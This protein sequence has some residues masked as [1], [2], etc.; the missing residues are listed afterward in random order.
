MVSTARP[1]R[2]L[3]LTFAVLFVLAPASAWTGPGRADEA[4]AAR[5]EPLPTRWMSADGSPK[6]LHAVPSYA[7]PLR[8]T[9]VR[10]QPAAAWPETA[11]PDREAGGRLAVVVEDGLYPSIEPKLLRWVGGL[12]A[13]GWTVLLTRFGA[14][15]PHQLR[16]Y[17]RARFRERALGGLAG[18][19]FVGDL[20]YVLYELNQSW[21]GKTSEYED[22]PCDL[23][24]MDLD[25]TWSDVKNDGAVQPGN[26]KYDTRA[27]D[28][29]LEIWVGRLQTGNLPCLGAEAGIF[30]NYFEKNRAFRAGK[31]VTA[32]AALVYDDD[33][34]ATMAADDKANLKKILAGTAAISGPEATTA[35]DYMTRRMPA[36]LEFMFTR[37]HGWPGG[38]G[39]YRAGK[40]AFERVVCG[41]YLTI[42]PKALF[43]S[44]FVCSGCDF[45]APDNLG[46]VAA[47]NA[48]SGLLSY[49]S[50][51]TGGIWLD[52]TLFDALAAGGTFGSSFLEWFNA[53]QAGYPSFAPRWWY[54]MV[55][56]GDATL[57]PTVW[58]SGKAVLKDGGAPLAGVRVAFSDGGGTAVTDAAGF[59]RRPLPC[60]WTGTATP[61]KAGYVFTPASRTYAS[62]PANKSG[63]NF[64]AG[65]KN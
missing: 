4:V 20:P 65:S 36:N 53:V 35:A 39:Y 11:G 54:G 8:M 60:G 32:P 25:G 46:G 30:N 18:A 55:L 41:D 48:Q 37:S 17:L 57:R 9:G 59:Y 12:Q 23:F 2:R 51:K 58:V 7:G 3:H 40:T 64:R 22:F 31:L 19:L 43:Y 14:G 38:H 61:S 21:D 5:K 24:F 33:D 28:Q 62:L 29:G 50:T 45:T 10:L 63:Q 44:F 26:G 34:W 52:G 42:D 1:R 16:S 13:E 6:P 47:F 27:G 49:G 15:T 56:L